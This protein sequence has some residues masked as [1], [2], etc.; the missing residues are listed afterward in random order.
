MDIG[1]PL[2]I[3]EVEEPAIPFEGDE[4]PEEQPQEQPEEVPA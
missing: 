3:I 4:V 2:E 1:K